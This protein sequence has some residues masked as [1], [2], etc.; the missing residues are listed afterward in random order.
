MMVNN[1]TQTFLK[2]LLKFLDWLNF[3]LLTL[4]VV[5]IVLWFTVGGLRKVDG[6]SMYPYLHNKDVVVLYKLAYKDKLPERGDVIVFILKDGGRFVKRVIALPGETVKVDYGKVFV[7]GAQLNEGAYLQDT[8]YTSGG[9][10]LYEGVTYT[11]PKDHIFVMGD[12]RGYST[13]SRD[14]GPIPL[15]RVEGKVL[16]IVYPFDRAKKIENPFKGTQQFVGLLHIFDFY[17]VQ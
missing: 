17:P 8:V 3:V 5:F 6:M 11:V 16:M 15:D 13:D 2:K 12:N 1:S 7:N 10:F 4:S 9:R 14:L